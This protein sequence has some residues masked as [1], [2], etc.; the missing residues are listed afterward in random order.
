MTTKQY[1][2]LMGTW[3]DVAALDLIK[4]EDI[5]ISMEVSD[6]IHIKC[7]SKEGIKAL[8]IVLG[9][10]VETI[11]GRTWREVVDTLRVKVVK[12]VKD[13]N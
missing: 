9:L 10:K 5:S 11:L 3:I 4:T 13:D 12:V 6:S 8:H 7:T 1:Y 2:S